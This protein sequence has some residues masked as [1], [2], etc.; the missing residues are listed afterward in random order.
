VHPKFTKWRLR[1]IAAALFIAGAVVVGGSLQRAPAQAPDGGPA[2][3]QDFL[4][5]I[6]D[7]VGSEVQF[8]KP[9]DTSS[10]VRDSVKSLATFIY[11]RAGVLLD[12]ATLNRLS[13][14]EARALAGS[15]KRVTPDQLAAILASVTQERMTTLTDKEIEQAVETMRGFNSPDLPIP[16]IRGRATVKM[17]AS[18][19]GS[20][21]PEQ[22][23]AQALA[24]RLNPLVPSLVQPMAARSSS[25]VQ[26]RLQYLGE[27]MPDNF[28]LAATGLMP[29]QAVLVGYSVASDDLLADSAAHLRQRLCLVQQDIIEFTGEAYPSPQGHRAYGSNGYLF[30]TP[31][32]ILLDKTT[33]NRFLDRIEK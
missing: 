12:D 26:E 4:G 7:G 15:A 16:F 31:L 6:R 21:T 13:D 32:D 24:F 27:A 29:T 8:A 1:S 19:E 22:T 25:A 5:R 10:S 28:G 20:L 23:I 14:L 11:Q 9:G 3:R 17:R 2:A 18:E 30:S 33:V